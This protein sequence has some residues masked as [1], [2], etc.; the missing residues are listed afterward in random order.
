[1][2]T[3]AEETLSD[4]TA[5]PGRGVIP[6]ASPIVP[7]DSIAGRALIAVVAIMTFLARWWPS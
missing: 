7:R 3:M 5:S 2:M 4:L 1:M 6:R